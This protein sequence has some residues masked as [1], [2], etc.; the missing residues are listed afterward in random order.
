MANNMQEYIYVNVSEY[1]EGNHGFPYKRL[2][3]NDD[4]ILAM[5]QN[6][7][8]YNW[9]NHI[10]Y[11]QRINFSKIDL[12]SKESRYLGIPM[13]LI[14]PNSDYN[15]F[16]IL[17]DMFMEQE[18]LRAQ[19]YRSDT[20]PWDFFQENR[21]LLA[22][23]TLRM[24]GKITPHNLRET[25]YKEAKEATSF[26]PNLMATMIDMFNVESVLDFSSGW[27]DRLIG[28]ISRRVEYTGV[29]PNT[30]LFE[31]YDRIINFFKVEKDKYKMINKPFEDV[32][33]EELP[34]V[35]LVMTSPPYFDLEKYSSEKTQS[36]NRYTSIDNWTNQFLLPAVAKAS[37]R[38]NEGGHMVIIINQKNKEE[39]YVNDMI[40]FV[41]SMGDMKYLGLIGYANEGKFIKNPQ[42]MFIFSRGKAKIYLDNIISSMRYELS[43]IVKNKNVM[44][45]VAQGLPWDN[46][47]IN[48]FLKYITIDDETKHLYRAAIVDG[49]LVG[50]VSVHIVD[51]AKGHFVTLFFDPYFQGKG[52][53]TQSL[54][55]I[56]K[57]F[58]KIN[59]GVSVQSDVLPTNKAAQ[60]LHRK[61]GFEKIKD[62]SIKG[63]RYYRYRITSDKISTLA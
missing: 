18:R 23:K 58:G 31:N 11:Q 54:I 20:S 39:K 61:V 36:I 9:R 32:E 62:I 49:R 24:Y 25:L 55:M 15:K 5:I 63:R 17:S 6:L 42:P 52:Y 28:A 53:G 3:Y 41:V 47:K 46:S 33:D 29:D 38:L 4:Q 51:Y 57:A 48:R 43:R 56:L 26:R 13:I 19:V 1:L 7:K 60:K 59:P 50:I 27:G 44:K 14:N 22:E 30:R 35:D 16:N 34:M 21:E 8:G 40:D 37:R 2:Y 45:T 12:S 10:M